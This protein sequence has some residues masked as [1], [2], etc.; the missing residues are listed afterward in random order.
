MDITAYISINL[1]LFS[2]WYAFLSRKKEC[3]PFADRLIGTFVLSLT[4]IIATEMLLGVVFKALS[5]APLFLLNGSLSVSVLTGSLLGGGSRGM[6]TGIRDETIRIAGIIKGDKVLL[7]I[8]GLFV[9]SLCWIVFLGYLFPSYSWDALYYHLPMVGQIL[10]SGAIQ[11]NP[12]PSFIQQYINIFSKN[13]NLIFLWNVIFL[14]SDVIVDLSQL[15]FTVAGILSV[16]SMAMKTGIRERYAIYASLLFYFTP[17]LILQSAVNYVDGAVSMLFIITVNFL[18]DDN[19]VTSGMGKDATGPLKPGILSLFMAGLSAGI[20]LGSK[21]TGPLF[22][23]VI[24]GVIISR[25]L[26]RHI[27]TMSGNAASPP[28]SS[29]KA[30]L[31]YF[32]IPAFL[33]G[34]YWYARNWIVYGNPVYYMDVSIFNVTL[35]KG[36]KSDWV[37]P[38]PQIIE[39]LNYLTRLLHVWLERVGYYMYDS[40]ESGFGPIW[41]TLFLPGMAFS[42]LYSFIKKNYTYLFVGTIILLTF[43]IHPRNWNTRYV[44]FIVGLGAISFGIA[45]EYFSRRETALRIIALVLSGYTFLTVNSPCIMPEKIK[46]F[47]HLPVNERTLSRHKPFNIDIKVRKEYGH[48]IW[49]EKNVGGGDTLAYTFES[50]VLSTSE[51]FFTAPLWNRAFSNTVV[52]VKADTY[53]E[54]L[55]KLNENHTTYILTR[56]DSA[57]DEWIEKERRLFYSLRWMGTMKEK[58]RI[59]YADE[60]YRISRYEEAGG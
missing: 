27:H 31:L 13:I 59:V 51:P 44:M 41:F 53:E 42:F 16:Y 4:Q 29:F 45:L 46:E 14:K 37:E 57:E 43:M 30:Y 52:Y 11:D 19:S 38:A 47:L 20:L 22:I 26:I 9:L 3:L 32:L 50:F 1:L 7:C 35:F 56:K 15:L 60:H 39:G 23:A 5:R 36:L 2:S 25:G 6:F 33:M 18:M 49:I 58:F 10:Q 48:W 12:T 21:P 54:W 40:R 8:S 34:G 55:Q 24:L 17:V 28:G